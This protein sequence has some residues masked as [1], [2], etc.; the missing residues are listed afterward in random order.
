MK[1]NT[2]TEI[3]KG[4][5]LSKK[6]HRS[7]AELVKRLNDGRAGA[8][9][10]SDLFTPNLQIQRT[11]LRDYCER[12]IFSDPILYA[13]KA[14]EVLWRKAYYDV[15]SSAKQLKRVEYIEREKAFLQT[16]LNAA[17]GFYH[18]FITRLQSDY[19]LNIN[20]YVDFAILPNLTNYKSAQSI[21]IDT[22]TLQWARQSVHRCLIYL[23]DLN[24]YKL[25]IYPNWDPNAAIRYYYQARLYDPSNGM[26]HNQMGTLATSL[27]NNLDAAYHYILCLMSQ[28]T[29]EGTE[30]NLNQL[31]ERNAEYIEQ[32]PV[33]LK[34][35]DCIVEIEAAEQ[36]KRFIARFLLLSDIWFFNK[37]VQHVYDLC[38]QTNADLQECLAFCKQ[39]SSINGDDE[40][41]DTESITNPQSL[42][43]NMIFKIAIISLLC[44]HKLKSQNFTQQSSNIVAFTLAVYLQ[45]IQ[46][47]IEHI[48]DAVLNFPLE[49][50]AINGIGKKKFRRRRKK[51]LIRGSDDESEAS[52]NEE[53]LSISESENDEADL[54]VESD[55]DS[56]SDEDVANKLDTVTDINLNNNKNLNAEVPKNLLQDAIEK[57]RKINL[58]DMLDIAQDEHLLKTVKILSDWLLCEPTVLKECGKSCRNL[59][60]QIIN[61]INLLNINWNTKQLTDFNLDLEQGDEVFEAIQLPED[62]LLKGVY[63]TRMKGKIYEKKEKLLLNKEEIVVRIKKLVMFGRKLC[64]EKE[65]GV[66]FD[67]KT[68]L[69]VVETRNDDVGDVEVS[70]KLIEDLE[71]NHLALSTTNSTETISSQKQGHR[72]NDQQ[73]NGVVGKRGQLLKMKHMGQLWLAAEVRDLENRVRSKSTAA[74][75]SPYL[76]IDIAS[77]TSHL[78]VVKM[79]VNARKFIVLVPSIVVSSLDD[80]KKDKQEAR[81]AIRW[82]ESQFHQGNRFFRAQR[83]QERLAIPL[84]KYPKKKDKDAF[85]Y[86][87][88]IECCHYLAEQQKGATNLVTLLTGDPNVI[89]SMN[90]M[91]EMSYKGLAQSAGVNLELITEFYTK[92][93]KTNKGKR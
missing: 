55:V 3:L 90:G 77:L 54:S 29:F 69:F 75:L 57:S 45:L 4:Q 15:V 42:Q 64:D 63:I 18:H 48:Q 49:L 73:N 8:Q 70:T 67:E 34:D 31:F 62:V 32:L 14:E 12:L 41:T 81:D 26:P 10:I 22:D 21:S 20:E 27:G 85:V 39:P 89:S 93:K 84:V 35:G 7:I 72:P 88:I 1:K 28:Q 79:L 13:R 43:P 40:S 19:E 24:R 78:A 59:V 76:V 86:T 53:I 65:M 16:H 47:V 33:D 92:W 50:P 80:L 17:I 2:T 83:Q 25:E 68:Q 38:H 91:K 71:Q 58:N 87:Q 46:T 5:E 61:L 44:L 60:T 66:A 51:L 37:K 23:G 56:T 82:L 30:N 36:I 74:A 52:E 11:K 6:L 9:S